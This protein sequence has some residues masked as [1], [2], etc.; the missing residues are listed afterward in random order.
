MELRRVVS[1]RRGCLGVPLLRSAA[2]QV[3]T[4]VAAEAAGALR[5]QGTGACRGRRRSRLEIGAAGSQSAIAIVDFAHLSG[6][7]AGMPE[8]V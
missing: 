5:A 7:E 6:R 3:A 2:I 1:S 4:G 8:A